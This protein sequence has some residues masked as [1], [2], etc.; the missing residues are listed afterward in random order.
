VAAAGAGSR[1]EVALARPEDFTLVLDSMLG[2]DTQAGLGC[3]A[4]ALL[5]RNGQP[6]H[7]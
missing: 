3:T 2:I 4:R 5:E 6:A 7:V 1:I